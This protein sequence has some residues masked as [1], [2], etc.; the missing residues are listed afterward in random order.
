MRLRQ[1]PLAV[2][3]FA[4]NG[5]A[6]SAQSLP[7]HPLHRTVLM[8]TVIAATSCIAQMV[9]A[10]A[11]ARALVQNGQWLAA[12][13]TIG[14]ACDPPSGGWR[15]PMINSMDQHQVASS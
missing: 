7:T 15:L 14:D 10:H 12:I 3:V 8:P 2:L 1:L 6:A 4:S 5:L 11:A 13:R 9:L